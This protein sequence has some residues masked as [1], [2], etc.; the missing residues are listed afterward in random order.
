MV[1]IQ[2]QQYPEKA[3]ATCLLGFRLP[4]WPVLTEGPN[5]DGTR[6]PVAPAQGFRGPEPLCSLAPRPTV[7]VFTNYKDVHIALLALNWVAG[8]PMPFVILQ[9]RPVESE[10]CAGS[11]EFARLPSL[12]V[13]YN[14][15]T[16]LPTNENMHTS[17]LKRLFHA[18]RPL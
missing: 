11:Q 15:V 8:T 4:A 6:G 5:G 7:H 1:N 14:E 13:P 12:V 3:H 2:R 10:S 18:Q 16:T 17:S 9:M